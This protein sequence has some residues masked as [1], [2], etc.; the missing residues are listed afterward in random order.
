MRLLNWAA[1]SHKVNIHDLHEEEDFL[2]KTLQVRV[3]GAVYTMLKGMLKSSTETFKEPV[4]ARIATPRVE[5][6][7]YR[8]SPSDP[9]HIKGPV[10]SSL[11]VHI[12][13]KRA[14]AIQAIPH[15]LTQKAKR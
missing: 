7:Y 13:C 14:S 12:A 10:S 4:K 5:N 9:V 1:A 8:P 2:V 3:N 11:V 6:N 15:F